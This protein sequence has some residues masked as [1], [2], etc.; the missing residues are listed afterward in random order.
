MA[1]TTKTTA[2]LTGH[3]TYTQAP[4]VC[5]KN[6]FHLFRFTQPVENYPCFYTF[7]FLVIKGEIQEQG[8]Q[9]MCVL[10]SS[11][12]NCCTFAKGRTFMVA[13]EAMKKHCDCSGVQAAGCRLLVLLAAFEGH[14]EILVQQGVVLGILRALQ[15]CKDCAVVQKNGLT[16]LALLAEALENNLHDSK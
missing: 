3:M 9:L 14:R 6:I 13:L 1:D 2:R 12:Q 10:A 11:N 7:F 5:E 8:I 16:A 4:A 15:N